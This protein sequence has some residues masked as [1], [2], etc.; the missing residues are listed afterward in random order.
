MEEIINKLN[1]LEKKIDS[2]FILIMVDIFVTVIDI[3]IIN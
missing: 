3:L 2:A 1:K